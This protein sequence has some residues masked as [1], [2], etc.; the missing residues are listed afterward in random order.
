MSVKLEVR[1]K[2]PDGFRR[3]GKYWGPEPQTVDL[4]DAQAEQI[5]REKQLFVRR[6]DGGPMPHEG[7]PNEEPPHASGLSDG[8]RFVPSDLTGGKPDEKQAAAAAGQ[9]RRNAM[10]AP[11]TPAE[12]EAAE[13]QRRRR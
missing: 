9:Q 4:E 13:E 12:G 11:A 10:S 7:T 2:S 3:G 8:S 1:S 5:M 6:L